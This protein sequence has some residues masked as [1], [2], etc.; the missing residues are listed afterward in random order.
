MTGRRFPAPRPAVAPGPARRPGFV[1]IV[2]S[3]AVGCALALCACADRGEG[4]AKGRAA[5]GPAWFVDE[6]EERG[7]RFVHRSGAAPGVHRLPEIMGGGG[8]LF[9]ADGDGDLDAYLVQGGDVLDPAAPGAPNRL[10]LN[11]GRGRF[12]DVTGASGAGGA[13]YGMG[14]AVGDVD[15]DARPDVLVTNVGRNELFRNLGDGRFE[16]CAA[17]A[18]VDHPGWGT[19]AAFFDFDLDGDLDPYVCNYVHWKASQELRCDNRLGEPDYCTPL[20]YEAPALDVLYRNDGRG[21]F[22]DVSRAAGIEAATGTGLGVAVLDVDEDGRPDVFVANDAMPNLLW[23][24]LGDGTFREDGLL[25]GCGVDGTGMTKAGMGVAVGDPDDDGDLDLMVCNLVRET[26]SLYVNE[27]GSFV[28]R[29]A[30]AGLANDSRPFTRF[31]IGWVDFD[32]DGRL[33]LYVANGRVMRA[34]PTYGADPYAEPDLL[35]R[36]V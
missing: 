33:D 4:R 36:G 29:T 26:D 11:D 24:N 31:G 1:R 28:D 18:G 17:A 25:A 19:S 2:R 30:R 3:G 13:G 14:V 5:A 15:G 27:R 35:F 7:L 6:A 22:V 12:E 16:E 9:D 21:R 32:H 8:A 20:A 23:R 10:F 34:H